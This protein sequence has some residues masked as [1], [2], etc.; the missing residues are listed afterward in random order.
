MQLAFGDG[1][2]LSVGFWESPG[3]RRSAEGSWRDLDA[4]KGLRVLAGLSVVP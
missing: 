2:D 4:E 3:D 1:C